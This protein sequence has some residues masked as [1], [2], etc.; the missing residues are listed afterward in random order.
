[1]EVLL[2]SFL[3]RPVTSHPLRPNILST[4][5]RT[6]IVILNNKTVMISSCLGGFQGVN[7]FLVYMGLYTEL[8]SW[9]W[10]G[11]EGVVAM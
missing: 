9:G 10:G 4:L 2:C 11:V 7:S 8:L 3:Q 1:M 6:L 5:S